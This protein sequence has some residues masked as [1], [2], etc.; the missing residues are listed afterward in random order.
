MA[1]NIPENDNRFPSRDS[2][3]QS[4]RVAPY[5]HRQGLDN[6]HTNHDEM[7]PGFP[8][9]RAAGGPSLEGAE[10]RGVERPADL[11]Q[12]G[13]FVGFA[14]P[15]PEQENQNPV[16]ERARKQGQVHRRHTRRKR[17]KQHQGKGSKLRP[18]A[19][20]KKPGSLVD[21][22]W[23]FHG[24]GAAAGSAP[25]SLPSPVP[26]MLTEDPLPVRAISSQPQ[27]HQWQEGDVMPTLDMT[28]FD[29]TDY[30]DLRLDL[31]TSDRKKG[32]TAKSGNET[33]SAEGGE[34]CDHHL[35][36]LSGSCCDLR[37]HLCKLHNRGLNN[38]CYDDCMCTEGLRCY[39][40]F[41][42]N[43]RVVRRRGRCVDPDS[44]DGD[45][46]SFLNV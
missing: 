32:R 11:R 8:G 31:W 18:R 42:R 26:Q 44:A 15:Y 1:A 40:K 7:L 4:L 6:Q 30:E 5:R 34:S 37:E 33:T 13:A 46:G 27:F 20:V 12:K 17:L 45:Q 21:H 28:L 9:S 36:C 10:S 23:P 16:P 19:L 14:V 22:F 25:T 24:E 41:H 3:M 35:D 39:A 2:W 38:K 29:W 43:R